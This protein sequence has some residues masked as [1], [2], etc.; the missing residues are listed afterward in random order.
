MSDKLN[1]INSYFHFPMLELIVNNIKEGV[2]VTDTG[3]TIVWVNPSFTTITGYSAEEAIGQN[4]RILKSDYHDHSFYKNL[5]DSILT[6][7]FWEQEIWN[8]RK[9]GEVYPELLS[10]YALKDHRSVTRYF[11]SI[12]TDLTD[13]K[14]KDRQ[15]HNYL[16]VDPLTGLYNRNYFLKDLKSKVG[17][18]LNSTKQVGIFL[19]DLDRFKL[20]NSTFGY[21]YGDHILQLVS[22]RLSSNK[23]NRNDTLYRLGEDEFAL[24]ATLE[25]PLEARRIGRDLIEAMQDHFASDKGPIYVRLSMGI[26][27]APVDGTKE[28]ELMRKA[29]IALHKAK[30]RGGNGFAFYDNYSE[31]QY[32]S[33]LSLENALLSALER[34]EFRM[35]FQPQIDVSTGRVFGAE[36]L[37]RWRHNGE[38]IS[39]ALFLPVA[40]EISIMPDI[41][42][43]VLKEC[44]QRMSEWISQGIELEKL[45]INVSA[46]QCHDE[47]FLERVFK[48]ISYADVNPERIMLE[49][50][51]SALM[52]D[53]NKI[54]ELFKRLKTLGIGVAIDD[55]GTGYSSLSYLKDFPVD[56]LKID[57]SFVD[58]IETDERDRVI[59]RGIVKVGE[60]MGMEVIAEGVER[61]EQLEI[62][63]NLGIRYVQGYLYSP[64]L[65][66]D[67]FIAFCTS[68]KVKL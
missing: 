43:W 39:P 7:G 15:L 18:A 63:R 30:S 48:I 51:E 62:L 5:W 58:N 53:R 34:K 4:P 23:K 22:K 31:K 20:I 27:I 36:A 61:M 68:G 2:V 26:V 29:E 8:R 38:N 19:M 64:P 16:Y 44:C 33:R 45:S 6:D 56:I 17:D 50:T 11:V 13:V 46:S 10:I 40:E 9:S 3:G 1:S 32:R 60:V 55:F 41:G 59:V 21:L 35:A 25:N 49:I 57:K 65:E 52:E 54:K 67:E 42:F 37:L 66:K 47:T 14:A 28:S 12:F 24:I